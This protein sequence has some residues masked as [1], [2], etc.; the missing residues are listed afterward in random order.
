MRLSSKLLCTAA[1]AGT[2]ALNSCN[3][4]IVVSPSYLGVVMTPRPA[5]IPA[6]G[7]M[8]FNGIVSNNLSI[9]QWTLLDAAETTSAGT[10]TPVSGSPNSIL[11]TA[12]LTPPIYTTNPTGLTQGAVTLEVSVTPPAGT[13]YPVSDDSVTFVITTPSIS[14]NLSP[15]AVNVALS[16]T[17]QFFGYAV[18]NVNNALTWSVNGAQGGSI[19]TGTIN[20]AGT[21]V[22]PANLPMG[23]NTVTI[24]IV[25]QADPTKTAS[26]VVTLH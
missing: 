22:A 10:L 3:N 19:S 18:G 20:T 25:S 5:S 8:V 15:A 11:Y 2:I 6:G 23:G 12:P 13:S 21:Y 26:A 7:T 17:Q 1:I 4:G 16:A 9:P 24:S 14:V